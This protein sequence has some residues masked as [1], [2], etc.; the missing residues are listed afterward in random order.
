HAHLDARRLRE[1]ADVGHVLFLVARD[2]ALPAQHAQLRAFFRLVAPLRLRGRRPQQRQRH[3]GGAGGGV[4]EELASGVSG[5]RLS[6]MVVGNETSKS[7]Q[8]TRRSPVSALNR[9]ARLGSGRSRIV[10][11]GR[12]SMRSR[13]SVVTS[14]PAI[15]VKTCVSAPVGSTTTTSV[16]TPSSPPASCMCSGRVP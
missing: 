7:D 15:L 14:T 4:F 12:R 1:L 3:G 6:P 13:N 10:S 5:H 9:W 2:E 8:C 11:P 16:A